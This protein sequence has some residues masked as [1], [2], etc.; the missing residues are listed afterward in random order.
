MA[1]AKQQQTTNNKNTKRKK[2]VGNNINGMP[3]HER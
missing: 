3:R 1:F 2:I